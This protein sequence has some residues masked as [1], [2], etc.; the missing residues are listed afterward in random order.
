MRTTRTCT[1][2]HPNL[3]TY[4]WGIN[5]WLIDA[6]KRHVL[7]PLMIT[8]VSTLK[9]NIVTTQLETNASIEATNKYVSVAAAMIVMDPYE[10]KD[11]MRF[12]ATVF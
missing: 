9:P 11:L 5:D 2:E 1:Y 4:A 10:A 6:N 8:R 3:I 7:P 12:N